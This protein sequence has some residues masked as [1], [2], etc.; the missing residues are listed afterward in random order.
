M[1]KF[2][3]LA[4]LSI[5]FIGKV[6]AEEIY[7]TNSNGVNLTKHEY[8]VLSEFYWDGYQ[9]NMS[10]EELEF[11]KSKGLFENEIKTV[12]VKDNP[13]TLYGFAE[14]TTSYKSL[15]MSSSCSSDCVVG[16]SLDWL[17]L[18][19]VR[20]YDILG[21]YFEN[22][23]P[24]DNSYLVV[25]SNQGGKVY[26]ADKSSSTGM[27]TS[28]KIP[29]NVDYIKVTQTLTVNKGGTVRASYQH[30]KKAISEANSRKYTFSKTGVGGVFNFG[31]GIQS[32]YDCMNGVKLDI[33]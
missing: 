19:Q 22:T 31:S 7:Y 14:H 18:P 1:K 3:V 21:F 17:K 10:N 23:S 5:L 11:L 32:Y 15:K 33:S 4:L 8:N 24:N 2:Y 26:T 12:V 9:Q 6:N 30:A 13:I 20:S 16:V 28:F 27:G 29:S 25:S